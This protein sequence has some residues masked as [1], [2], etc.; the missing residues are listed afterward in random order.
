MVDS[1]SLR[2]G[3]AVAIYW[4]DD[5]SWYPGFIQKK[6]DNGMYVIGYT[7]GEVEELDLSK[8]SYKRV[9]SG[10]INCYIHILLMIRKTY[11]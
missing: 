5:K 6:K 3:A 1:E 7:D 4:P 2:V 9:D 8:E 10:T 11:S